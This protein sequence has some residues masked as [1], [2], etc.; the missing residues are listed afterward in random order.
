MFNLTERDQSMPLRNVPF[1]HI[2]Y[3]MLKTIEKQQTQEYLS[4]LSPST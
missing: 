4:A 3:F 1:W 2:D